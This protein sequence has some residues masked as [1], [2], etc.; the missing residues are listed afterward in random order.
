[1][2]GVRLSDLSYKEA[3]DAYKKYS[4]VMLPIGG[5]VKEHGP[6]LPCGT[7]MMIINEI[8]NRVVEKSPIILLPNLSYGHFPAFIDWPASVN[9][10]AI[11]LINFVKDIISSFIKDGIEKFIILDGGISTHAPLQIVASELHNEFNVKIAITKIEGLGQEVSKSVCKQKSGGHAD[12]AETSIMLA[13]NNNLV[14]M[15]KA[16][17]EYREV[18]PGSISDAGIQKFTIRSKLSTMNGTHGNSK[19]AT[20]EK[21]E[22]ILEAKVNDLLFFI[23]NFAKV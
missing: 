16:I 4:I 22:K 12:E 18:I 3:L 14:D 19:L 1:V 6:H 17:E 7:D 15:D 5:G 23:E 21:G 13:I 8:A 20:K 9:I 2:K 11:N 10:K